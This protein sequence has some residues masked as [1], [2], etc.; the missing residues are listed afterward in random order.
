MPASDFPRRKFL[1]KLG[2]AAAGTAA[3]GPAAIAEAK[4]RPGGRAPHPKTPAAALRVLKAGNVRYRQGKLDL[5]NY[6]PLGERRASGQKPFAAI[7]TCADSRISPELVFDLERGN[8]FVSRVAGNSVDTGTLGSTEYAVAVLGVKLV[9][10]L[11]H[12]DCGAVKA[13]IGVAG[14]ETS[15][16]SEQFGAIGEVVDALVPPIQA[17]PPADRTLVR[18]T[19]T[20]ARAQAADLASRTPIIKPAIDAGDIR[21]V[22]AIYNIADGK[23][24]VV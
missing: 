17:I 4:Q 19:A 2:G 8:I 18:C 6:S 10:V 24:S 3:L 7:I 21:V 1:V 13:A 11:G 12:S 23:V 15:Y 16:P 22:A 20:N 5:V 9:M 14:G